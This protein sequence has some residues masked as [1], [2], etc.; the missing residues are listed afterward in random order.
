MLGNVYPSK[1]KLLGCSAF[2][3]L[4][5]RNNGSYKKERNVEKKVNY[6]IT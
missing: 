6:L 5:H 1:M 2:I 4:L 3:K